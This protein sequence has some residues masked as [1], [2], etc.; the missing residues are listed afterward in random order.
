M[1]TVQFATLCTFTA[2][3]VTTRSTMHAEQGLIVHKA[4][5]L[6]L[7]IAMTQGSLDKCRSIGVQ[8]AI[9]VLDASGRTIIALQDDGA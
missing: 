3:F 1:S 2:L 7:S 9:T 8:C 5:S 4:L 6:D